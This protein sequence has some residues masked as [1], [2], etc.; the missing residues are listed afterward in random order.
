M[1]NPLYSAY[2]WATTPLVPQSAIQPAQQAMTTPRAGESPA[3]AQVKGFGAGA[4]EGLRGLTSPAQLA[5]LAALGMGGGAPTMGR[6]VEAAPE[7]LSALQNT[8]LGARLAEFAPKGGEEVYNLSRE[9]APKTGD[10]MEQVYQ[11]GLA[12]L[13]GRG[14]ALPS[15]APEST[16]GTMLSPYGE[17]GLMPSAMRPSELDLTAALRGLQGAR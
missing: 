13:G 8:P 6:A 14:P 9:A 15:A 7:A 10:I 4:L 12:K 5:G 3:W 2:Q 16:L 17:G 1:P 11:R